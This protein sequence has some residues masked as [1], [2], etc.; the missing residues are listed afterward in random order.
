MELAFLLGATEQRLE[1]FGSW[2]LLQLI[3]YKSPEIESLV[4]SIFLYRA[5]PVGALPGNGDEWVLL[6]A[7]ASCPGKGICCP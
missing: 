4:H 7:I 1:G 3:G 5:D 6:S 2:I